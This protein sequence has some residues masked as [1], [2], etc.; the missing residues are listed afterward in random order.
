MATSIPIEDCGLADLQYA[1]RSVTFDL[2]DI[3]DEVV[4]LSKRTARPDG[5]EPKEFRDG[6]K[7][8]MARL[9]GEPAG[10]FTTAMSR[11]FENAVFDA[12]TEL[13]KKTSPQ[14]P[15]KP[16]PASSAS[17]TGSTPAASPPSAA[18]S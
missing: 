6:I 9:T 3:F 18:A 12:A 1:G 16:T 10:K 4:A 17:T 11:H 7:A 15:T 8:I 2:F 5:D 14:P 13:Q